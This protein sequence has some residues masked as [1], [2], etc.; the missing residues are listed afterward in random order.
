MSNNLIYRTEAIQQ[1]L[2]LKDP[3]IVTMHHVD[4]Y[5]NGNEKMGKKI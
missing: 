3:F 1:Q 5:S 2:R 4:Y